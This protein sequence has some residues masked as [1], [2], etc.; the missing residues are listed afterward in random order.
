[1][2]KKNTHALMQKE[3]MEFNQDD[4]VLERIPNGTYQEIVDMFE[5]DYHFQNGERMSIS[6]YYVKISRSLA[7]TFTTFIQSVIEGLETNQFP[8]LPTPNGFK[9]NP[10]NLLQT[11]LNGGF[12]LG[13]FDMAVT[14]E[15][16]KNIEFQAVATYPIS[17]AK[18]N[19][20]LLDKLPLD[21]GYIFADSPDTNW[22]S[23]I[24]LYETIIGGNQKEGILLIDRKIAKQ[25]TNFEFFATQK[26]LD[27]PIEIVD[28]K[29]LFEKD[30]ALFY[31]KSSNEQ[32]QKVTRFY[33]RILLA[34]A[35]FEDDY[36]NDHKMWR[37]RFDQNYESLKFVNHP[38]KQFEVSKRLSPHLNHPFN[39]PCYVLSEVAQ[40]FKNGDLNYNDYV[41]KHKWGA[42]G[43]RL[44]LSPNE[45]ILMELTPFWTDYIAQKK[46]NYTT[47]VTDDNQEK[48]V[49]L[50]FMTAIHNKKMIIVPMA[51]IGHAVKN[52]KG[53]TQF[54]IHFGDNNKEGYGFSPVIIMDK[55]L[56]EK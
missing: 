7:D 24:K 48:I 33:N 32:P 55:K 25:K 4:V 36:P 51:R 10:K 3:N 46:V 52:Q 17:A 16:L 15:G 2:I 43:H 1:M 8:N 49:E 44:I 42:A 21:N 27:L 20:Y 45:Q 18:I 14:S 47:F 38:I 31:T 28:M 22:S 40:A 13:S 56:E 12:S 39:P 6:N 35:L 26:E 37:F 34:E 5:R 50:R 23:F 30:K 11:E 54:K 9:P 19:Q 53:D 41:W 29:D